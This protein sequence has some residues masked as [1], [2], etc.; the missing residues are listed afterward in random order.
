MTKNEKLM[1][2]DGLLE[3][4]ADVM[5]KL[6]AKQYTVDEAKAQASLIKQ[7]NNLLR[8]DLDVKKFEFNQ[9]QILQNKNK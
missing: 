3:H 8:Y 2:V 7:S 5:T 4:T 1:T 6:A 9:K